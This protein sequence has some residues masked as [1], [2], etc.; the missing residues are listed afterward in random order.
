MTYRFVIDTEPPSL[1][2]R[3]KIGADAYVTK[4]ERGG[5]RE[6]VGGYQS[7]AST[8]RGLRVYAKRLAGVRKMDSCQTLRCSIVVG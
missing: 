5:N 2:T 7:Y 4:C 1:N 6:R 3:F 8:Q